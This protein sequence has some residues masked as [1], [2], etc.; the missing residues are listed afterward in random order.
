MVMFSKTLKTAALAA[1]L[2][3]LGALAGCA[4]PGY[5]DH[6]G[7]WHDGYYHRYDGDHGG[8]YHHDGDRHW[9]CDED[10]D[11]CHWS[12]RD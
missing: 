1:S 3:G 12:Y 2:L 11:N 6:D 4:P 9:T 8:Y 5:Y 10:G 7:N